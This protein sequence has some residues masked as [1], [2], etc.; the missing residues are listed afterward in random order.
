MA[1]IY[2]SSRMSFRKFDGLNFMGNFRHH[3]VECVGYRSEVLRGHK[4][5][6]DG[7]NN[8]VVLNTSE[9]LVWRIFGGMDIDDI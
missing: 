1:S 6:Y 2:G 7:S 3:S 9:I 4:L 5:N 8:R